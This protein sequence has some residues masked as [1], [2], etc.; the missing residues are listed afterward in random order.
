MAARE[1]QTYLITTIVFVLLAL[2]FLLVAILGINKAT[3]YADLNESYKADLNYQEQLANAQKLQTEVLKSYIGDLGF[4][5]A[6]VETRI[7]SIKQASDRVQGATQKEE[8]SAILT[9][10]N[11]IKG[12]YEQ[13]MAAHIGSDNPD[14]QAQDFTW[15]SLIGN[16]S[17]VLGK[18]HGELNIKSVQALD[19][20]KDAESKIAAMESTVDELQKTLK[21]TQDDLVTE[22]QTNQEKQ[23]QLTDALEE[24]RSKTEKLAGEYDNFQQAARARQNELNNEISGLTNENVLLKNKINIYEREVFDR[25]DGQIV[26]VS[27]QIGSV[28]IDL[29]RADGLTVNR[30]FAIYDRTVTNFEKGQHKAMIEVT[31]VGGNQAE[32]RVTDE[33]PNDPILT[34]DYVL[35]A[36]WD[37]GFRVPVALAGRFDLDRDGFDDTDK[38]VQMVKRNGGDVVARHDAEGNLTGNI[39]SNTR[40]LVLGEAP[41]LGVDASP[42]IVR[43]MKELEDQA[44]RNTVQVIGLNKLLNRMGV[45]GKPRIETL[46][47][48][49]KDGFTTR[50][51]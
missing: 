14:Q 3:E 9:S 42:E 34:G 28:F 44:D 7:N 38:L 13:D 40:Y 43:A 16:L 47:G 41:E 37:P 6:E 10:I 29:G 46:D 23:R 36:T 11:A 5:V 2:A 25:P 32:A 39:D 33:N 35:T 24:S 15:R 21:K 19:A 31:Q 1:N 8:I 45:R 18:K 22:K 30:T 4:S 48:S 50:N 12:L 27:P 17:S 49:I 20:Q 51:P 26:K